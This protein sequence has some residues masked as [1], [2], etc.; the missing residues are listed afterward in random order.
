MMLLPMVAMADET[1]LVMELNS[2]ETAQY[3]L[4][5]KPKLTMDGT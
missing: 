5:D 4:L 3:L 2:G 1:V